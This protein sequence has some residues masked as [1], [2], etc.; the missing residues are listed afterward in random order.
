MKHEFLNFY[1]DENL[2]INFNSNNLML[3][4]GLPLFIVLAYIYIYMIYD[5][6]IYIYHRLGLCFIPLLKLLYST[7]SYSVIGN[8]YATDKTKSI[9]EK[10]GKINKSSRIFWGEIH[11]QI[12]KF[13]HKRNINCLTRSHKILKTEGFAK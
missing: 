11:V 13:A 6:Y 7:W 10:A 3:F 5:I 9:F 4:L 8:Y 1:Q 2:T 12:Q